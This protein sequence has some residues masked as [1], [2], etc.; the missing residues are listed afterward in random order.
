MPS[1]QHDPVHPPASTLTASYHLPRSLS[2]FFYL[3]LFPPKLPCLY[4]LT[5]SHLHLNILHAQTILS[6]PMH[7]VRHAHYT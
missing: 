1:E 7:H 3:Y 5:P 6:P 2:M 4:L